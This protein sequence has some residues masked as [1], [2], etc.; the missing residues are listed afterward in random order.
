MADK[1][2]KLDNKTI[3]PYEA[4]QELRLCERNIR[5]YKGVAEGLK[6]IGE[7][8]P[9]YIKAANKIYEWQRKAQHIT[10][11]T[12][13]KRNYINEF[14]GTADGKQPRGLKPKD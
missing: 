12:G 7:S 13:I 9:D 8:D 3:T 1:K 6:N 5:F 14:I 2:V 4:E 10:N 11:E